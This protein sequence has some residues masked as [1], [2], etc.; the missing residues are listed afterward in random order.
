V[1][2]PVGGF[3][4]LWPIARVRPGRRWQPTVTRVERVKTVADQAA[5]FEVVAGSWLRKRRATP[6]SPDCAR[7]VRA[8]LK[9]TGAAERAALYGDRCARRRAHLRQARATRS[10]EGRR[11]GSMYPPAS[12]GRPSR[13]PSCPGHE[14]SPTRQMSLAGAIGAAST[15]STVPGA[16][17]GLC[18]C[19]NASQDENSCESCE[20]W[21]Q[22]RHSMPTDRIAHTRVDGKDEGF[23]QSRVALY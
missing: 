12:L 14:I 11:P 8:R 23:A 6:W 7:P 2:P 13:N 18:R 9:I 16:G 1:K 10:R 4:A 17:C 3:F 20:P 19:P 15:H 22:D 21:P 5:T